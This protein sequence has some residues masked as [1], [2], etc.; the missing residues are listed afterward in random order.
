MIKISVSIMLA[1]IILYSFFSYLH[2]YYV[3]GITHKPW[4]RDYGVKE[5]VQYL[6]IRES[7]YDKIIMTR[8]N[9]NNLPFYLF[10]NQLN[11]GEYQ[12]LG[13]PVDKDY[14]QFGKYLFSPLEC[15]F[16]VND[17]GKFETDVRSNYLYVN[18]GKCP[19]YPGTKVKNIYRPDNTIV[20]K[21]ISVPEEIIQSV[22]SK[23][24]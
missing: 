11:P 8:K 9:D 19:D 1:V 18:V 15:V 7:K 3:H 20:F 24:Q 21:I 17:D 2:Q 10:F 6:N 13:S 23:K 14:L 12:A 4:Y 16:S 22:R 5:L